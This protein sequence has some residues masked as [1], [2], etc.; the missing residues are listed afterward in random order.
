MFLISA[1][2][3]DIVPCAALSTFNVLA[4]TSGDVKCDA[5]SG[6]WRVCFSCLFFSGTEGKAWM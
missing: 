4:Q 2:Q 5:R 1:H 3:K 6:L